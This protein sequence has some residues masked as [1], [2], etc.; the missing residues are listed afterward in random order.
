MEF[1]Y[2]LTIEPL[3]IL[4]VYILRSSIELFGNIPFS[5][6]VLSLALN[7][8]LI[9][10]YILSDRFQKLESDVQ[11]RMQPKLKEFNAVFS[12]YEKHL[13]I[14]ELHKKNGYKS[15]Y[16]LRGLIPLLIQLP[17]FLATYFALSNLT[18][19]GAH[20]S[21]INYS[22]PD[23]II[24]GVNFFPILM[25]ILNCASIFFYS[26]IMTTK[27]TINSFA[28]AVIFLA[29]LYEAPAGL[30]IHWVFN[31]LISLIKNIVMYR[32]GSFIFQRNGL[33]R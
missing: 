23:G 22:E 30:A 1:F 14:K 33:A 15:Y 13:M 11:R 4:I 25:F 21:V 32:N 31:N 10:F 17:V 9:P 12:G 28:V 29:L 24:L 6:L 26:S 8:L 7:F 19:D 16:F 2:G 5:L 18:Y 27:Q 3:E 20:E